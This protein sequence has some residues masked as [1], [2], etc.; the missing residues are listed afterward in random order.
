MTQ[1]E[2]NR[3]NLYD[4]LLSDGYFRDETGEI[5]FSFEDFCETLNDPENIG[6]FYE[7]LLA[8]GYFRDENGDVNFSKEAFTEMLAETEEKREYY[9]ICENQRGIYVDWEMNRNTTQYNIPYV[10]EFKD[11]DVEKLKS[12]LI[13]VV[14]AHP[15]LKT[16]F[17][18][19]EGDIV[20]LRLDDDPVTV[21]VTE[22]KEEPTATFFQQRVVPFNLTEGPLYRM[23]IYKSPTS[24]WLFVDIHHTVYDGGSSLIFRRDLESVLA[25]GQ[26]EKESYTAFDR[27][28]AEEKFWHSEQCEEAEK[29]FDSLLMGAETT[30]YPHSIGHTGEAVQHVLSMDVSNI[31]VTSFCRKN[32]VTESNYFLSMLM[33]LLHRITREENVLI[34]TIH[35]GRTD[36]RMMNAMGMFVKTQPVVSS[37]TNEQAV[38]TATSDIVKKVQQQMLDA[39]SRDIY[40]FTKMV[41]RYG[42]RAEIMF[43]FQSA[44][45]AGATKEEKGNDF[46]LDLDT[47][48]LPLTVTVISNGSSNF[49]LNLEYNNSLY[50]D[51]DMEILG[52]MLISA[53]TYGVTSK[54]LAEIPLVTGED[55][56]AVL[57]ESTGKY[58][59][60]DITKTFAQVFE[61]CA[62]RVPDNVAVADRDSHLTY[63]QMSHYSDV[64]GHQLVGAGV[65]PNDFVCVMLDRFKEF[66]LSVLAIHKA[67]AAYTPMDFE[68]PNERLQYMLENSEA[69]VLITSHAVLEAKKAEGVFETGNVQIIFIEDVDFSVSVE[70]INLTTP[71]N[72]AYMIY[73]SGSTGKPKGAMLHQAGLWN[74][75]NIVIDMEHLTA[76]DRIEGHRSFSFDAHIED[77]YPILTLGGSFHI[78]PTEIR[79][80][81]GAIRDFLFEHNI[82]GGGYST[83]IA[84]LLLNTYNDLPVRFITAG[85][86]KLDGVFSD[87][88][89]IINVYG[90]TECTDDTSYYSIAPGIRMENIPIGKPVANSWNFIVDE[91]GHLVPPGVVGEL[92]IAG[93]L[94]GRGY[95]RLPERTAQS[96]VDCPFVHED[97]WGRKVRMYHTGDLCRWNEDGD[98]EY[99]GRIDFQVKLR[100]FRIELGEIESK[101]LQIEGIL[102][103]AAEVRKVMGTE[104]LVLY[105]TVAD[106]F[107]VDDKTIRKALEESALADYMVPDA[108]ML[109][110]VMPMTPNGKVNRKALPAPEI[111]AAEIV[112]AANETE[113]QLLDMAIELLKHDRFGVTTNL[114]SVGMTS[115]TAM[116]LSA[117][118]QQNMGKSMPTKKILEQ[119]TIREISDWMEHGGKESEQWTHIH[120]HQDFYPITENQR[121]V[122]I[123]WELNSNAVQYNIPEVMPMG[124]YSAEQIHDALLK[125]MDAHPYLKTHLVKKDGDVMQQRRDDAP[126]TITMTTLSHE[127][128]ANDFEVRVK[129]FNLLE[130]DLYRIEI[131][132][133]P[134]Q[135]YLFVD[136][137]H[138][139][140]DGASRIIFRQ[141]LQQALEHE[142]I[143]HEAYSAFDYALDEKSWLEG[144]SGKAAETWFD[145]L[146]SGAESILY[147]KSANPEC[148][149]PIEHHIAVPI[150]KAEVDEFCRQRELLVS[151]YFI[152]AFMQV[153]HRLTREDNILITT[154]NHGR[155]TVDMMNTIGMF[156]K[157]L[158]VMSTYDLEAQR[159][160]ADFGELVS[161]MSEQLN[162]TFDYSV[163]PLT[164]LVER[165]GMRPN[166]LFEWQVFDSVGTPEESESPTNPDAQAVAKTPITLSVVQSSESEYTLS[167]GYDSSLYNAA[168]MDI[169]L[170]AMKEL[171][172][173]AAV[174]E[175]FYEISLV[176][177]DKRRELID[178]SAG[179]RMDI[180][181]TKTYMD[182]FLARAAQCPDSLAVADG[183]SQITYAQLN[184]YS[185]L[186]A[187][188]L[189]ALGVKKH[190]FVGVMIQRSKEFPVCV[191]GIHKAAG[192]YLPLD[193]EYPNERLQYM[194]EDSETRVLITTHAVL[195][196]KRKE[197]DFNAE[198]II[199]LDEIDW[200]KEAAEVEPVNL[201]TPDCYTYIIYTSGST[202]K[203]KGVV[204]HH[205]GLLNYIFSTMEELHL[206]AEDRIS[207]HRSF[208]F[209]SHIED[210]YAILLLGGS[211]HIMPEEIR[212]DLQAIRNFVVE[213]QITGGGYTTSIATML[214][215][216]FDMPVRYLSAIGEKLMGV[217]S[218]DAQIINAYGP[219]ECTDHITIHYLEKDKVYKDIPIGHVI[220]N[221]WCFIVDSAG[222]LAPMGACG[223]L[224]IAGI[225]VGIGYW[226]LPERT[227]QSFVD[228][229]F[230]EKN[231][232]GSPVRMYHTGDLA[233][234]NEHGELECL[235]RID[236]QVKLRGYRVELGEI[237]T[238]AMKV[239]GIQ[240]A[241]AMIRD[242]NN[243]KHL[244]L[245]YTVDE[246]KSVSDEQLDE[247][248]KASKLPAYM[249]PEVYMFVDA[250]PRTP[251]G[252][253]NRRALPTPTLTV[254]DIVE[255]ETEMEQRLFEIAREVLNSEIFGVT[256]NLMSIGMNSLSAMRL[257]AAIHGQLKINIPTKSILQSPTIRDMAA[258]TEYSEE[259]EESQ[260]VIHAPREYYPISENQR[261]VYVDWEMNRNTTQ[262]NI[263]FV[264]RMDGITAEALEQAIKAVVAAHPYMKTKFVI[265][266]D[267]V[268]QQ[269]RDDAPVAVQ[270]TTISDEPTRDYFQQKVR[271]FNLLDDDLYRFEIIQTPTTVWLFMD[272]HHTIFD[273]GSLLVFLSD[274]QKQLTPGSAPL[275][276]ETYTAWDR[277]LDEKEMQASGKATE[278]QSYFNQVLGDAEIA[279]YPRS[280]KGSGNKAA[281]HTL[282]LDT[283][284][285]SA[286]CRRHNLTEN[287]FFMAVTSLLLQRITRQD[288]VIFTSISNGRTNVRMQD[289]IG[290]FVQTLPVVSTDGKGNFAELASDIQN[291]YFKTQSYCG[292][293]P[294]T[295]LVERF[296]A[297]PEI[298]FAYQGMDGLE[299]ASTQNNQNNSAEGFAMELD[300]V[301]M[302]L[303]ITVQPYATD[304]FNLEL[305]YAA[306]LYSLDDMIRLAKMFSYIT[307]QACTTDIPVNTFRLTD[308]ADEEALTLLGRG[309]S[310]AYDTTE[311]LPDMLHRQAAATPD[312]IY[313]VYKNRSYTYRQIDDITDR[314]ARYLV[315]LGLKHEQAVGVMIDRS[316][317]L[318]IYS[319]AVMKAG[320]SYMPLDYH[321]PEDRLTFMTEDA[322]VN[323]I[324][325]E[326]DLLKETMPGFKGTVITRE[327]LQWA[328]DGE[329]R[330][331]G[332]VLPKVKPDDRMVILF[333]SGS[334]G[335]PKGVELEQHGIVNYC[336]WYVKEFQM[337]ADDRAVG[338]ANYGFDAHMIDIYPVMLVGAST[339]ILPENMRLDLT[340]MHNYL[341]ENRLTIA[342]MTTQIGCQMATLFDN[343]SLRVLSTGGEKMPPITPPANYRFVN[344]YGPTECSLFSTFYDVKSY[345]EG[346]FIGRPLDN[347]Q[348]Y[349]IDKTRNL[350]PEGL[351]GELLIAG[352][353]V[354]R[355]YL[356]RP[357]LTAEKFITFNGQRA[358]RSGD[359]VRWAVDPRD[360]SKQIEFLG[361]ID[362]QVKLRGLRIELGEIENRVAA[363]KGIKQ[364]CVDVKE[365]GGGQNLV[366]YYTVDKGAIV[367]EPSLKEWVA[368]TLA[369][370][371]VPEIFVLLDEMPL[372]PNGKVNRRKLPL[373]EVSVQLENIPPETAEEET[374]LDITRTLLKRDDFGVTDNLLQLGLTSLMAIKVIV[375]ALQYNINL[376]VDD[377]MKAK[378]VRSAL[379]TKMSIGSWYNKYE[380]E[381]PLAVF[382]H[383]YTEF[384][385][386]KH[387]LNELSQQFSVFQIEWIGDHFEYLFA[388]ADMNE[389]IEMYYSI[390]D[391]YLPDNAQVAAF[392]GHCFGGELAYRLS[393]KWSQMR[394][395]M[396]V[397]S[398]LDTTWTRFNEY[399]NGWSK[400]LPYLPMEEMK[401]VEPNVEEKFIHTVRMTQVVGQ[402]LKSPEVPPYSGKVILHKAL[403]HEEDENKADLISKYEEMGVSFSGV[404]DEVLKEFLAPVKIIDNEAFW[405][406][407]HPGIIV[408]HVDATHLGML[409]SKYVATYVSRLKEEL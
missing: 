240:Q 267:D 371:M 286:Y 232:D 304:L 333:T 42:I 142:T 77:M 99:M 306:D 372:T 231:I 201:C 5:N 63:Q 118:I 105:Y 319:M 214:V 129:P 137:H 355:G 115:L 181:F 367:F 298:M 90:P 210:L 236:N 332:T 292:V 397:V 78:M 165:Y 368:E 318:V 360:G 15:Y 75:I 169:V 379:G 182:H 316:E 145:D 381:K 26:I 256:T 55:K 200:E 243:D 320:G 212:K 349:V 205:K 386:T 334:T 100:G 335:K 376:K 246:G 293:Y 143:T 155:Q 14:N 251:N 285:V 347:Y 199:Y 250:M 337:T 193:I 378:S 176:P 64:L 369:A 283:V 217:V 387:Y 303:T 260:A 192:A 113:Q 273:G 109:M 59:D 358:Y 76:D 168:D 241:V 81:V 95:W 213:H 346:E 359:L 128:T 3:R 23:E 178:L 395:Q 134:S 73:T 310:L 82:T 300:A 117:M 254:G 244:V 266:E 141:S 388:D 9:P 366:C 79:K 31:D 133:S 404:P 284:G 365:V 204:L 357:D 341:E 331:A 330:Y 124:S 309:K 299:Q 10:M 385:N 405:K 390:L 226:H 106:G 65:K 114:V 164:R 384:I 270:H 264:K 297:N 268:M 173:K 29:H 35:H 131:V 338:Y 144:E 302:P 48:K 60:V 313:V 167:I 295:R 221:S 402:I 177:E 272:V 247:H 94:V 16:H 305:E 123:D 68:Y 409:E 265:M 67:G 53:F 348:L 324:L 38:V 406:E 92:C 179:P 85:G 163:Y 151:N 248:M 180:D 276:P 112:P 208:S 391:V 32:S 383:G 249:V 380:P 127:P 69:K 282:L 12:A 172:E 71:D 261:G 239:D 392:T 91:T 321:F 326:G 228:C 253:I 288:H 245:Y 325:T 398:L 61:E 148:D 27:A 354:G 229:P 22:L 344:P 154:I 215:N 408:Y 80:D 222:Q 153:L 340:A 166:I 119:P 54:S 197:G 373:P 211:L 139:I 382:V 33:S 263:P 189:I 291:Q 235:G 103:A 190:D 97:R 11:M 237:E 207:S 287:S 21:S 62:K 111:K 356:N 352:E 20:Q 34:T 216:T 203:P 17:A 46:S 43:V 314:L 108:Y 104:H 195:E 258:M 370:F 40:T 74:F 147:P 102:Q 126:V 45:D 184:R 362:N 98:L 152:T 230:V 39:Q 175:R 407:E 96:F 120:E 271:P 274:L 363:F 57:E 275:I 58:L 49:K 1:I 296:P 161:K 194:L 191:F 238:E 84:A 157:T 312:N 225:Q 315:N 351:P 353:G 41:E 279:S 342:F 116:R 377:L 209:D 396:P 140:N 277:A 25:G 257:S 156:V 110:D 262:Y 389:V 294:Y 101:V 339:Y 7:N 125:V 259:L 19:R 183:N 83:A 350:V 87:H 121:G 89:E 149:Q 72:L 8:D 150:S 146:I 278:A 401:R 345:F 174:E 361:R 56:D 227:A 269:R 13:T 206:T 36:M 47:A 233:R 375:K 311:T 242:I 28:L 374:L 24:M 220:A 255:P 185:D 328:F 307:H 52:K 44:G 223:E 322:G 86:E 170:S 252:K 171:C 327:Q 308:A 399:P 301:K 187:R 281:K 198:I 51:K 4:N 394:G 323:I 30:V 329:D 158:P 138:I 343:K 135:C 234:F 188:K 317:L 289:I 136:I 202:G 219:T 2:S 93:I 107:P 37:M 218:R 224:C 400:I 403:I 162:T 160:M 186:I 50:S 130:E 132:Q 66:P 18:V 364:V 336:H 393:V 280:G 196:E 159:K 70:P 290:M 88:I 6:V 122:F